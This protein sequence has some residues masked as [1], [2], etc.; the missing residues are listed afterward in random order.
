MSRLF[1]HFFT[2]ASAVSLLRCVGLCVL[3]AR[4]YNVA[5]WF[6]RTEVDAASRDR[7]DMTITFATGWA[8]LFVSRSPGAGYADWDYDPSSSTGGEWRMSHDSY[9]YAT[10]NDMDI[11]FAD[12]RWMPQ[13][14]PMTAFGRPGS[15]G[16]GVN[17]LIPIALTGVLPMTWRV[18]SA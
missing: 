11:R 2:L 17:L 14:G 10:R 15:L 1:R 12:V 13:P 18:R 4:T 8:L 7:R 16:F 3:W 9:W 6:N 5:Y